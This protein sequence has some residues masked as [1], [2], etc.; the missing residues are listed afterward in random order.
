MKCPSQGIT[1]QLEGCWKEKRWNPLD[2]RGEIQ[3]E[4]TGKHTVFQ[5]QVPNSQV[6]TCSD[7]PSSISI[8]DTHQF[9]S[10]TAARVTA[11]SAEKIRPSDTDLALSAARRKVFITGLKRCH[12]HCDQFLL[13]KSLEHHQRKPK[14]LRHFFISRCVRP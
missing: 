8:I 6:S 12:D 10:F 4:A 14:Q 5:R 13:S 2:C 9:A 1:A 3:G 11:T 7:E